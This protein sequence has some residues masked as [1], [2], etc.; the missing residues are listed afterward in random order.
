MRRIRFRGALVALCMFALVGAACSSGGSSGAT[1]TT[2]PRPA[3]TA[4]VA[5]VSPTNGQTFR[6][7]TVTVP[8]ELTLTG[9][10]VVPATTTDVTPDTGHIH[11]FLD[12]QIVTMNFSLTG[13][14]PSV[15]PGQ[16]ILRAEFVAADHL[17]F[18]PRVFVSVTFEV[19]P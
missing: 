1:P 4:K 12:N 18:N 14:I 11:L 8:V 5:V 13:E 3:S 19:Q 2:S 16:H 9:A 7:A 10:K 15:T 17:P 6:G